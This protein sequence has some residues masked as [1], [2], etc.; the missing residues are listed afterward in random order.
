MSPRPNKRSLPIKAALIASLIG[1]VGI[2]AHTS[3]HAAPQSDASF[4]QEQQRNKRWLGTWSHTDGDKMETVYSIR[5][6][7]QGM[8]GGKLNFGGSYQVI[9]YLPGRQGIN[10]KKV[11]T[12]SGSPTYSSGL[13]TLVLKEDMYGNAG[14][15]SPCLTLRIKGS[16]C[17]MDRISVRCPR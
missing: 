4:L 5:I 14:T 2:I 11:R 17:Y 3:T 1:L 15:G 10:S 16:T 6:T 8:R 12:C 9:S 13:Q 7:N